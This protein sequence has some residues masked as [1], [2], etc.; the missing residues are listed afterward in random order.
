MYCQADQ[1]LLL[2]GVLFLLLTSL[3]EG[4]LTIGLSNTLVLLVQTELLEG[5]SSTQETGGVSRGPVGETVLDSVSGKL[6]RGGSGEDE[7]SLFCKDRYQVSCVP[8]S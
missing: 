2:T 8:L 6:G 7:V 1:Q 5:S 3:G 4:H